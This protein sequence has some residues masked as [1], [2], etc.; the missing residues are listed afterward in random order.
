M[1]PGLQGLQDP[2]KPHIEDITEER[3]EHAAER[4]RIREHYRRAGASRRDQQGDPTLR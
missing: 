4:E 1:M 2:A 3:D